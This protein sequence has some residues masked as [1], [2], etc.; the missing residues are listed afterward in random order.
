VIH[1]TNDLAEI[2]S[3]ALFAAEKHANQKRKGK[4]GEPY[5]NHLLE[6]AQLVSSALREPDKNLVIAALLHDIIQDVGVTKEELVGRF[7]SDVAELVSE[8]TDDKVPPES[9][10]ETASG[11][12]CAE[13]I[14]PGTSD[15][16]SR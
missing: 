11:R 8:V 1:P 14:C 7:G 10:T 5:V 12:K 3:A 2:L 15:Q 9:G 4:A 16:S 6:V 13:E